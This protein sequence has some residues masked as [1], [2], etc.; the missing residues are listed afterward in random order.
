VLRAAL[1]ATVVPFEGADIAVTGSFGVATYPEHALTGDNLIG[2]ADG[3]LYAAKESGR[4]RVMSCSE[5][6]TGI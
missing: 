4:N 5:L 3:A 2:A 1:A 6:G